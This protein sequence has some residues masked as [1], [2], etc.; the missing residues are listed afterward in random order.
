MN[1]TH[2]NLT[3]KLKQYSALATPLL[4]LAGMADAQVIYQDIDPD[5]VLAVGD[6]YSLDLN[7]DGAVDFAFKVTTYGTGWYFAGLI[8]YPPSASNYN[9]FAGYTQTFG[10]GPSIYGFPSMFANGDLIDENR[11]WIGMQNLIWT[12]SGSSYYFYAG[13]VSNY[14]G[15][16]FGQW[17]GASD[18]FLGIR[19]SPDGEELHY[20]WI[21]CD[22]NEEGSQLTIKDFAYEESAG[23]P[24]TAGSVTGV[25]ENSLPPFNIYAFEGYVYVAV[26]DGNYTDAKLSVVNVLGQT[27][28]Q[29][30]QVSAGSRFNLNPFGKG[31]Y[32]VS[33][34][35]GEEIFS[36]KITFR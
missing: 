6:Q 14:Y 15:D 9:A 1:E 31:V 30:E 22:V 29:N 32:V 3:R 34:S 33:V 17:S 8:P 2:T 35:R 23:L 12:S 5:V 13:M 27:V 4:A 10:G 24:I 7:N 28:I 20:A 21:R 26:P 25:A 36:R 19:F 11:P 18:R 16:I